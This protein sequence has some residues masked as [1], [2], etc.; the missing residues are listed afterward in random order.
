VTTREALK[1]EEVWHS[2]RRGNA[3][4]PPAAPSAG[5]ESQRYQPLNDLVADST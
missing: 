5:E 4:V 3:Y 2:W 1:R